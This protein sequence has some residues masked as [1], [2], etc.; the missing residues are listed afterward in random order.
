M[1]VDE[2]VKIIEFQDNKNFL[3]CKTEII[4]EKIDSKEELLVLALAIVRKLEK[5]VN[6][7]KKISS[8][9]INTKSM[10]LSIIGPKCNEE[11]IYS[12][13]R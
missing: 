7:N 3:V 2:R 13:I 10:V 5:L 9:I 11:E 1:P 4:K 8:E 6:L 12:L